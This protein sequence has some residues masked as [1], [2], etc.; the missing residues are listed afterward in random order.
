M[1]T[2]QTQQQQ[3][4]PKAAMVLQQGM[5]GC[6]QDRAWCQQGGWKGRGVK[7]YPLPEGREQRRGRMLCFLT[8]YF[9]LLM[10]SALLQKQINPR[11]EQSESLVLEKHITFLKECFLALSAPYW[12]CGTGSTPNKVLLNWGSWNQ[13]CLGIPISLMLLQTYLFPQHIRF[14][15]LKCSLLQLLLFQSQVSSDQKV[16]F[17]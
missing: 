5:S 17:T 1:Q 4:V 14:M 10:Q 7:Q 3:A 12:C 6:C 16:P 2:Q 11:G 9:W 8:G 15:H 13:L